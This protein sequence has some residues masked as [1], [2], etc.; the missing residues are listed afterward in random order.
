MLCP[1]NVKVTTRCN[2]LY[3]NWQGNYSTL[4]HLISRHVLKHFTSTYFKYQMWNC[5]QQY[6]NNWLLVRVH[7]NTNGQISENGTKCVTVKN[8]SENQVVGNPLRFALPC[9]RS[10]IHHWYLIFLFRK[11]VLHVDG[12]SR[13]VTTNRTLS[14]PLTC[15]ML[16]M[17][18]MW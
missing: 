18:I 15:M 16:N 14:R 5:W 1:I 6:T 2:V 13:Y 4:E 3:D 9:G 11:R 7:R 10:W 17:V 12:S 8:V